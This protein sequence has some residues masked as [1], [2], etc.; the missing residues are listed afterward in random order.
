MRTYSV[1]ES[2]GAEQATPMPRATLTIRV[3]DDIWI[4]AITRE[5]PEASFRILAAFPG[6]DSGVGLVEVTA[7]ELPAVIRAIDE[8]VEVGDLNLLNRHENTALVQFETTQPLL[9]F[10]IVGSGIPLELPFTLSDGTATWDITTSQDRLSALGD[11]LDA[12]KIEY[13]VEEIHY[14]LQTEQLLTDRQ[15]SLVRTAVEAGYYDTPRG[16]SLTEL[17][18]AVG[19]AKSTTSE[20]LHRAEGKIIKEFLADQEPGP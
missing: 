3:P 12:F 8:A 4:G 1:R 5:Y 15:A 11:Q 19:L 10:P 2:E 17:A 13:T 18:E 6:D 16:C 9:L 20:T 7:P 14:H